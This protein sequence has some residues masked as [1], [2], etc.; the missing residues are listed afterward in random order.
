MGERK[1]RIFSCD[2]NE[3]TKFYQNSV[4]RFPMFCL[5]LTYFVVNI[6][7][8]SA[9]AVTEMLRGPETLI[10]VSCGENYL[11]NQSL[12]WAAT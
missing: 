7:T 8:R 6:Y 11:E 9:L 4:C 3:N 2:L 5:H 10:K 1:L 12:N